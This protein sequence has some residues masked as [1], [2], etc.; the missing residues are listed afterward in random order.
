MKEKAMTDQWL[1]LSPLNADAPLMETWV[2][3]QAGGEKSYPVHVTLGKPLDLLAL[4]PST[5]DMFRKALDKVRESRT[6]MYASTDLEIVSDCPL[7]GAP[8]SE[9]NAG[10]GPAI[11]GAQYRRCPVCFHHF[12]WRRWTQKAL[13]AFYQKDPHY[14]APYVD[15]EK[16]ERLL[17]D[18]FMPKARWAV[19]EY[20]RIY[21]RKPHSVLD[22]GAG[23][24]QFVECLRRLKIQAGGI[25]LSEPA[26]VFCRNRF[27][28]EL[29][30]ADFTAEAKR[31]RDY[32]IIT[33]WG[34]IEHQLQ[35]REMLAAAH[36]ALSGRPA[37]L[38]AAVPRWDGLSTAVQRCFPD[39]VIRH[40]DPLGHIHC[41][42]ES[43]LATAFERTGF[44]PAALWYYGMDA[45]ELLMNLTHQLDSD[46]LVEV[47]ASHLTVLQDELDRGRFC[48]EMI[49]AGVPQNFQRTRE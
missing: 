32:D 17:R 35:P 20:E 36:Q 14:H 12:V 25:E 39:A 41:F 34:V 28:F 29:Q 5:R 9:E 47:L 13:E 26:R 8:V 45:Y 19:A 33:F 15:P 22:V 2:L 18:V 31:F 38:I 3:R 24:G 21:G 6:A 7:C 23:G 4:K 48:D 37:L 42:S 10:S 1:R 30:A 27:G 40:L 46:R 49:M 43:S 16:T 11:Y 44:A